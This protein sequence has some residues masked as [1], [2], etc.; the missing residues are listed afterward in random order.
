MPG[1]LEGYLSQSDYPN[2]LMLLPPPPEEGS[3]A[4]EADLE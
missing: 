3:K 2:S 4:Y 1:V